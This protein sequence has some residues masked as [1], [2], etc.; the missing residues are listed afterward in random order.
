MVMAAAIVVALPVA[1]IA[2][3]VAT[4]RLVAPWRTFGAG[5]ENLTGGSTATATAAATAAATASAALTALAPIVQGG[6]CSGLLRMA[7][8]LAYPLRTF[9]PLGP[10]PCWVA[11]GTHRLLPAA[12]LSTVLS[13][14]LAAILATAVLPA[15][16]S[17]VLSAVLALRAL[18]AAIHVAIAT[19]VTVSE[20]PRG[21]RTDLVAPSA[22]VAVRAALPATIAAALCAPPMITIAAAAVA[23]IAALPRTPSRPAVT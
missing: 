13:T 15:I 10:H 14:F 1:S 23:F 6:G 5:W 2:V 3:T 9:G 11:F 19:L 20:V 12:F 8:L 4:R 16:L 22:M 21:I 18:P 17:A 7:V